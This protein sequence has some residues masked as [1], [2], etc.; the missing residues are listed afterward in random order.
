MQILLDTNIYV[1]M[2]S[3][4][5]SLIRDVRAVLEDPMSRS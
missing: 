1:Y 2:I 4:P 5:K 3:D